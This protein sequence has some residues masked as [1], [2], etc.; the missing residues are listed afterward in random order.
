MSA[1]NLEEELKQW[2]VDLP[3]ESPAENEEFE[4]AVWR[5]IASR[6]GDGAPT[7]SGFISLCTS[8]IERWM[9]PRILRPAAA[10][11][12]VATVSLASLHAGSARDSAW[13]SLAKSYG[14]SIDP[15]A[16]VDRAVGSASVK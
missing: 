4:R 3:S 10:V 16:Q 8:C 15:L 2:R 5:K 6:E 12:L 9:S 11:M 7:R 1:P 13:E 14:L